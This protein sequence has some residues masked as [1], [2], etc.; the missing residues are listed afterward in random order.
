MLLNHQYCLAGL[1]SVW[2]LIFAALVCVGLVGSTAYRTY[3]KHSAPSKDFDWQ[4]RGHSDF[5]NGIYFPSKAFVAGVNPYSDEIREHYP[6][7]RQSPPYSPIVF[8]LHLPLVLVDVNTADVIFFIYNC[9]LLFLLA[10]FSVAWGHQ[11]WQ[12]VSPKKAAQLQPSGF[13]SIFLLVAAALLVSRP[14]H[15]TLFTGYFTLELV[16]GSLLALHYG[17]K[18]PMLSGFG[19]LLASGKPTYILP[20]LIVMLA[21]RKFKA[22]IL[23]LVLCTVAGLCGLGWL[24]TFS[25]WPAVIAGIEQGQAALQEDPTELPVNTWTRIDILGI[26]SKV[27]HW[28][29]D[30]KSNLVFMAIMMTVVA[31]RLWPLGRKNLSDSNAVQ[32]AGEQRRVPQQDATG[33]SSFIG[34]LAISISI[35]HHSYD[36][37]LIALPIFSL[38][39]FGRWTLPELSNTSRFLVA[40]LCSVPMLNFLSTQ[41]FQERMALDGQGKIW[42][43]ITSVNCVAL[44]AATLILLHAAYQSQRVLEQESEFRSSKIK[45]PKRSNSKIV[46]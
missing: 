24:A 16:L 3:Q 40:G 31:W 29:P 21:Q 23:G 17:H 19:M 36:A 35:Y 44:V 45:R 46:W 39:F 12:Q 2:L 4:N 37:L 27:F 22:T 33:L 42:L 26:L 38:L 30:G 25:S 20:L 32:T 11:H 34:L 9:G 10:W 28:N 6:I 15:I 14:G 41:T 1:N 43:A 5:H 13:L 8:L 7:A 18:R